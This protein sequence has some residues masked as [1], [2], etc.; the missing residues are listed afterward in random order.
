MLHRRQT[1][2]ILMAFLLTFV[3]SSLALA[4][5]TV[6][7]GGGGYGTAGQ[8]IAQSG[9]WDLDRQQQTLQMP[10]S[11]SR[12]EG[13][14]VFVRGHIRTNGAYVA[15]H[16]RSAPDEDFWNN[17]STSGNLN[18]YTGEAGKR[19]TPPGIR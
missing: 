8:I 6:Q 11:G 10:Y 7:H 1:R 18:P 16:Y 19:S 15:P 9:Q 13:G 5:I 4:Q 3:L 12:F 17:W 14:S 2:C